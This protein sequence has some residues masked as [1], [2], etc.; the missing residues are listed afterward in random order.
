MNDKLDNIADLLLVGVSIALLIMLP[1]LLLI[2]LAQNGS[3]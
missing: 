1:A 3:L 2:A